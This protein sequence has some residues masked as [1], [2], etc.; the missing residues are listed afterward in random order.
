M[1]LAQQQ[2]Y[3]VCGLPNV[4]VTLADSLLSKIQT[5]YN[6]FKEIAEAQILQSKTGKTKR[7]TGA[8][9]EIKG[10]GPTI[11][12]TAKKI[13]TSAYSKD[14]DEETER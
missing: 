11:V 9:A 13:L 1:T 7:L 5:P 10:M 12:D 14:K 4:G 3:L 2:Q 8:I 6:V